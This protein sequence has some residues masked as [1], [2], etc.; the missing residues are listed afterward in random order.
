V[1]IQCH[2]ALLAQRT[3]HRPGWDNAWNTATIEPTTH[4]EGNKVADPAMRYDR[5][6]Q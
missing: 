3:G 2:V 1:G 6:D 4:D 5:G